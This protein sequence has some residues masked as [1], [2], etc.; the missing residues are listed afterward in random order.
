MSIIETVKPADIEKKSF[1]I[2]DDTLKAQNIS[3]PLYYDASGS[4]END[5]DINALHRNII[6]RCIHTTADFDY[7]STLRFSD[8]SVNI[9]HKLIKSGADIIT[10]TNMALTG[11][12]KKK[13]RE[14]G[15]EFFCFMADEDVANEAKKRDLTRAYVAMEHAADLHKETPDKPMIFAVGNAPTALIS[16]H[17]LYSE[18]LFKP[19][20]IIGVP[21]GFVNVV[22]SKELIMNTDIPYII[23]EGNKG[24]SPVA[25]AI[26]NA[27]L[28]SV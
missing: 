22:A 9:I 7:A 3:V 15:G 21:V 4:I 2:I 19:D 20:F 18:D 1:E 6:Y 23:N 14:L 13:L 25:A 10:D 5:K 16:L 17:K 26:I 28:Y 8:G 12:N 27:V 11:I 24:G